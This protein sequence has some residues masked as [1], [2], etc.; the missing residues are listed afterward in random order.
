MLRVDSVAT[1]PVGIIGAALESHPAFP[2]GVNVGF[3]EFVSSQAIRLR[4]CERG[5]GETLACGTGAAAAAA[6]LR[7]RGLVDQQVAVELPGGR[8][9]VDWP[10]EGADLWQTGQTTRVFEGLIEL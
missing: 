2:D 9:D 3:A 6:T 5:I 7:R 1:A 10:G 4:V 8:L